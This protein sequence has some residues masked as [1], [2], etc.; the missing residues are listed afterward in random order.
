MFLCPLNNINC[1]T[2]YKLESENGDEDEKESVNVIGDE[3]NDGF[4]ILIVISFIVICGV[5]I[6]LVFLGYKFYQYFEKTK[7]KYKELYNYYG[8][9]QIE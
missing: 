6:L 5:F 3:S 2:T 8:N 4:I 9:K 1:N 7:K